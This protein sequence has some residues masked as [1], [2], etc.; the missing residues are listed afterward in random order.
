MKEIQTLISLEPNEDPIV[1]CYLAR[2]PAA[3]APSPAFEDRVRELAL[4]PTH[5]AYAA[6]PRRPD[7]HATS[8]HAGSITFSSAVNAGSRW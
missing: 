6:F 8:P 4:S 5:R 1:S 3:E 7:R 2:E